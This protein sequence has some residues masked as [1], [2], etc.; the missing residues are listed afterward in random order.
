MGD[1][2]VGVGKM[3]WLDVVLKKKQDLLF[4]LWYGLAPAVRGKSC[5]HSTEDTNKMV[6]PSLDGLLGDISA[7]LI[8][9]K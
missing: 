1:I 5:G 6:F 2:D 8:G 9:G 7:V 4:G 3:F